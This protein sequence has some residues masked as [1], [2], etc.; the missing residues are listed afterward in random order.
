MI[1][2][3]R[4]HGLDLKKSDKTSYFKICIEFF[5]FL[6]ITF[7]C[8]FALDKFTCLESVDDIEF[9]ETNL[10]LFQTIKNRDLR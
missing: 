9:F 3:I 2:Q 10:E 8:F 1:D 7:K 5:L 6:A 4:N